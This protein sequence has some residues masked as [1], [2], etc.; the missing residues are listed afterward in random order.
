MD[1]VHGFFQFK[2]KPKKLFIRGI[3]QNSPRNFKTPDL[4]N[5]NF[6]SSD[7]CTKILR[8]T[9]SFILYIYLIY[10]YRILLIDCV[11]FMLGNAVLDPFFEDFQDQAF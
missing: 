7:S 4:F 6:K 3:L 9:S 8:I 10:V 11:F 1:R 2:N 5:H